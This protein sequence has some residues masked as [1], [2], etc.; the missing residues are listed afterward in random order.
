MVS[1]GSA[2]KVS[3]EVGGFRVRV[4][5]LSRCLR[6]SFRGR[7]PRRLD[8]VASR[9]FHEDL[10]TVDAGDEVVAEAGAVLAQL[11]DDQS[12]SAGASQRTVAMDGGCRE[13]R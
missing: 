4:P 13:N 10:P 6:A 3:L 12:M 7:W 5:R 9:V 11:S 8:R 1:R 2:L